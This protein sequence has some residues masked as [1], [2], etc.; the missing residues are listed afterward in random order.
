MMTAPARRSAVFAATLIAAALSAC[1]TTDGATSVEEAVALQE[2]SAAAD[3]IQAKGTSTSSS[4]AYAA[5]TF[6]PSTVVAGQPVTVTVNLGAYPVFVSFPTTALAGPRVAKTRSF[7]LVTDPFLAAT[8]T[9]NVTARVSSPNPAATA[10]AAL[11]IVPGPLAGGALPKVASVQLGAS[12]VA[13]GTAVP[14]VVTLT[15]AAPAGGL[16]VQVA[17]SNDQLMQSNDV[18]PV[19]TVPA[20]ATSA[21]FTVNTHLQSGLTSLTDFVVANVYGGAFG[22]AAITVNR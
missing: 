12:T 22:G 9:V 6:S 7:T 2:A 3:A 1:G 8:T 15:S 5:I 13:S 16:A 21:S 18:P 17:L 14:A 20:G 4:T 19:V 11:T 10:T